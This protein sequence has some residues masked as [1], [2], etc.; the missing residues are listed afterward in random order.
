M[1]ITEATDEV[2]L[3]VLASEAVSSPSRR[4]LRDFFFLKAASWKRNIQ[5]LL[6]DISVQIKQ[7]K[8]NK[9]DKQKRWQQVQRVN[10]EFLS[11]SS[12]KIMSVFML[13]FGGVGRGWGWKGLMK[14]WLRISFTKTLNFYHML[15]SFNMHL[16]LLSFTLLPRY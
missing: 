1:S 8:Q 14:S 2:S 5:G 11:C 9:T 10:Q 12:M 13:V 16:A 15:V 6:Q 3:I 4:F 7:I